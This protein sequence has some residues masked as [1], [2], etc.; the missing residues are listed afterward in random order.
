MLDNSSAI[1]NILRKKFKCADVL[2]DDLNIM[3]EIDSIGAAKSSVSNNLGISFLPYMSIKK[4]L[5]QKEF[6][7]IEIEDFDLDP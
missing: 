1:H 3:F 7:L 2:F 5:Y 4:E 6:K